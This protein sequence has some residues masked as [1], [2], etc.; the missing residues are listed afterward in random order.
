MTRS[1]AMV[2]TDGNKTEHGTPVY[3]PFKTFLTALDTLQVGMPPVLDKSV[4]PSF[5]GGAQSQTMGAFKF[6]GLVDEHGSVL[7]ILRR[8]VDATGDE[9]KA[10]LREIIEKQYAEALALAAKNASFQQLLELLRGYGVQ[11]GT[12]ERA[13]RF[14]MDA[15]EYTNLKGS[16]LWAK[17]KKTIRRP[18]R[19]GETQGTPEDSGRLRI[20]TKPNIKIV[21]L[22]S[23]GTLRLSIDTDLLSLSKED[24]EWL[25]GII[26]KLN[27]YEK[28]ID[29]QKQSAT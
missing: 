24:R 28:G 20:E 9:R 14:F 29:E 21:A 5:S 13:V 15:C 2:N 12:L 8:L 7:P 16:P 6:L 11:G 23:G 1:I 26:D 27:A 10:V 25:F 3:I 4:W 19:K 17:A 22:R 18:S